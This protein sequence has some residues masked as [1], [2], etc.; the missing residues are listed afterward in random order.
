MSFS[1]QSDNKGKKKTL[2]KKDKFI[3]ALIHL[4]PGIILGA[5][6]FG[7]FFIFAGTPSERKIAKEQELLI[8]QYDVL[9]KRLDET[10]KVLDD[11][12]QRDD[13]LY[14]VMMHA[15]PI[16]QQTRRAAIGSRSRYE[17][18]FTL[19]D[20][21]LVV[22]TSQ[23]MDFLTRQ[24]YIQSN[25]FDEIVDLVKTQED[26]LKCIPA[27]QPVANKDLKRTASGYGWRIDPIYQ[28]QK[29]HEG[30]DFSAE[31]GTPIFATGN[32]RVV[33][34]GW[35]R[36]YGETVVIDHGYGYQTLYAHMNKRKVRVGTKVMRGDEIGL[37]GNT[38]KSTGPHLHYEVRLNGR[39]QNPMHYYFLDLTPEEYD[40]MIQIASN[41]GQVMD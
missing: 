24:L 39:H 19:P 14:R 29:F 18:L 21:D 5:F 38:G 13:N 23:K 30:M 36:G 22:S 6:T 1:P 7:L 9:S 28:T 33:K 3:K 4:V 31:T 41:H 12:Q 2:A 37:V 32:G 16:A 35:Q 26:R 20:A 34:S 15:E 10:L 25:S 27:I 8:K 11:I 17:E 40:N